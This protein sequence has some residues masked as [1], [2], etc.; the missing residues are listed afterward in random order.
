LLKYLRLSFS[1]TLN[2]EVSSPLT[3]IGETIQIGVV[4]NVPFE[5]TAVAN[6]EGR[7]RELNFLNEKST[8]LATE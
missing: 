3:S 7:T 4:S 1:V 8:L 2:R 5:Y 6:N